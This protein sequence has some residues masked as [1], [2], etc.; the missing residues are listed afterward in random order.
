MKTGFPA[1]VRTKYSLGLNGPRGPS[2]Y[3]ARCQGEV[4]ST[5]DLNNGPTV[6]GTSVKTGAMDL[7]EWRSGACLDTDMS[8]TKE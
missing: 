8:E 3:G 5:M 1:S 4:K 6:V 2:W 7:S